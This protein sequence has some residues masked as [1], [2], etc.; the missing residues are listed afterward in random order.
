MKNTL[1]SNNKALF[2]IV[3]K[4]RKVFSEVVLFLN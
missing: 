1:R 4:K 3:R 2:K